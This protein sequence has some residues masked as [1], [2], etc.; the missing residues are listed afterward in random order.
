MNETR[1]TITLRV[2]EF[3]ITMSTSP[4][5]QH[6]DVPTGAMTGS[7]QEVCQEFKGALDFLHGNKQRSVL[8]SACVHAFGHTAQLYGHYHGFYVK[9]TLSDGSEKKYSVEPDQRQSSVN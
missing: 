7:S 2:D 8:N 9:E 1:I 4:N 6:A 3:I 5:P